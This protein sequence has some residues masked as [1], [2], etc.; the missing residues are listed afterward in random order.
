MTKEMVPELVAD[1]ICDDSCDA[2]PCCLDICTD[3]TCKSCIRKTDLI[4]KKQWK[5]K[6]LP[7]STPP[8]RLF[9]AFHQ[10][11]VDKGHAFLTRCQ[12]RRHNHSTSAWLLCGDVI[13]DVTKYINNHPGGARSIIRKSGGVVDCTLDMSFH[14]SRSVKLWKQYRIGSLTPC[15]GEEEFSSESQDKVEQCVIC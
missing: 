5:W 7:S 12:V 4:Q 10:A 11:P 3:L 2:C 6:Q 14:S 1:D 9:D 13:Y 15:P 8:F